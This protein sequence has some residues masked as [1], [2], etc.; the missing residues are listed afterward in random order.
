MIYVG[1]SV[2]LDGFFKASTFTLFA[3]SRSDLERDTFTPTDREYINDLVGHYYS[4]VF[5]LTCIW[6]VLILSFF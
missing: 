2:L 3:S 6:K 4:A 1:D 5:G